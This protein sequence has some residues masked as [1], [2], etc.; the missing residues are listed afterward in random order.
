MALTRRQALMWMIPLTVATLMAFVAAV[1]ITFFPIQ[2]PLRALAAPDPL[3]CTGY[4]E[5]RVFL[6][7]QSWWKEPGASSPFHLHAGTC[8][9]LLQNM[10]G[11]STFDVQV[12]LHHNPGTLFAISFDFY[13]GYEQFVN[14]PDVV[15]GATNDCTYW[16]SVTVNWNDV[17]AGWRELRLKPRIKLPACGP[18]PCDEDPGATQITSSG[19]PLQVRGG[20][21]GNR[22]ECASPTGQC[23]VQSRGWYEHRGYANVAPYQARD[24][25]G[26]P[27]FSGTSKALRWRIYNNVG[28]GDDTPL[29]KAECYIDP[30]FHNPNWT[31]NPFW[32]STGPFPFNANITAPLSGLSSGTHRWA[33]IAYTNQPN[34][35]TPG[36]LAG[37][38]VITF[39]RP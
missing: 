37:V 25:L 6:E 32:T 10:S 35:T 18:A 11:T 2:R 14:I 4:P 12:K 36:E 9:P 27:T 38:G 21:A 16:Y 33:C 34:H 7:V 17:P 39:N 1:F 28:S 22:S 24:V 31:P 5:P 13:T 19:W 26:P 29:T 20:T 30:D 15:C 3:A 23:Q 8:F